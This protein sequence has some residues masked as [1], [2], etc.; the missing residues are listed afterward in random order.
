MLHT[1]DIRNYGRR[2]E[3]QGISPQSFTI[4]T[5]IEKTAGRERMYD[6]LSRL[7]EDR[8][9]LLTGEVEDFMA[10]VCVGQ[11][12]FLQ[13]QSKERDIHVYINSPGG[14]VTSG[15][16]MYD[17]IQF[18]ACPVSTICVGQ[19]ASMGAIL[20]CGGS[21]GKRYSLPHSRIMIHQPSGGAGGTASDME[22]TMKEI[23]VLKDNLYTILA[24]HTGKKVDQILADSDR[25]FYLS[26]Q[27]AKDYG[28]IDDVITTLKKTPP[29]PPAPVST[30]EKTKKEK[31]NKCLPT[32]ESL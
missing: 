5:V 12:L 7:M 24:K 30:P 15:L 27:E 8:I 14:S 16:A 3:E 2:L 4:P 1:D 25:D 29:V 19:A 31:K 20:L 11:L 22:R 23:M 26:A 18:V 32:F 10:T 6:L 28:I 17:V 13:H 21:E 9:I